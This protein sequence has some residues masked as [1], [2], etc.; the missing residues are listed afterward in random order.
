MVITYS[1]LEQVRVQFGDT[2]L[3]FNPVSKDSKHKASNFGAD[4][5]LSTLNHPDMNG[6]AQ[7]SR[8]DKEAFA[9]TGPGEYEVG[10][11]FIKGVQS[12]S[13]YGGGDTINTIYLVNMENINLCF[14]GA[15]D[16]KVLTSEVLS[17]LDGVDVLFLPIGGKGV[18]APQE[19]EKIAVSL[20]PAIIIPIHYG[21]IGEDGALK[22][23]LKEAG[24]EDVKPIDKLTIKKKDLENKEGEVV[25]LEVQ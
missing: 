14:L 8:G 25:V 23:F 18:L 9:I 5:V 16:Q 7:A 20:E 4:I 3:A 19:A 13:T 1:G 2:V 24:S 15:L 10:G 6:I 22:K 12:K 17:V 11:I 21:V